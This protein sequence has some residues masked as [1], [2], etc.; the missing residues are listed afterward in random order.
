MHGDMLNI[1]STVKTGGVIA[2]GAVAG[3]VVDANNIVIDQTSKVPIGPAIAVAVALI[4][5]SWSVSAW[6]KGVVDSL[7]EVKRGMKSMQKR[8]DALP[9]AKPNSEKCND[10]EDE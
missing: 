10:K 3:T 1:V 4:G 6:K 9:C 8:L 5:F 2:L 7:D